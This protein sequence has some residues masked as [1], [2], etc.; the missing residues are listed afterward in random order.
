MI[1]KVS[2]LVKNASPRVMEHNKI[3]LEENLVWKNLK[4]KN[5]NKIKKV[6]NTLLS[7]VWEYAHTVVEKANNSDRMIEVFTE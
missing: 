3:N 5:A 2:N 1:R 7:E 6:S 4:N